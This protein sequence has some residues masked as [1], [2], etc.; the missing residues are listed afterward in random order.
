VPPLVPVTTDTI[1]A[2]KS[3]VTGNYNVGTFFSQTAGGVSFNNL[4]FGTGAEG[5]YAIQEI[6]L[7]DSAGISTHY[8]AADLAAKSLPDSF[9]VTPD[10]S[11]P[12]LTRLDLPSA[13]P[14]LGDGP[15]ASQAYAYFSLSAKDPSGT[16][17]LSGIIHL[18]APDGSELSVNVPQYNRPTFESGSYG[19]GSA[20]LNQAGLYHVSGVD[21]MDTSGND[22]HYSSA[23][24]S[25]AGFNTSFAVLQPGSPEPTGFY[26]VDGASD[27]FLNGNVGDYTLSRGNL[28]F[29]GPSYASSRRRDFVLTATNGSG[30]F[31]IGEAIPTV[32]F[33]NGQDLALHDLPAYVAGSEALSV[34]GSQND[35]LYQSRPFPER[36]VPR[37]PGYSRVCSR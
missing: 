31:S 3:D 26:A 4:M 21:V 10:T 20:S 28:D 27:I 34:G 22:T 23:D 36:P 19:F 7:T 16:S 29:D 18:S 14:V 17:P 37:V 25:S 11:A 12:V 1:D 24:L 6:T 13:L 30:V 33:K 5:R 15:G 9:T 32:H 8:S 2:F 35:I